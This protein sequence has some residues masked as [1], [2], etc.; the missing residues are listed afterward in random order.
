MA[1]SKQLQ[2]I[3]EAIMTIK[4][5]GG[6]FGR[7]PTFNNVTIEGTL[8]FDGDIDINSDLTISGNLYLPGNSKAIF[9]DNDDLQIY[10]DGSNSYISEVGT[11]EL[12]IQ[13]RDAVTIEDGTSGDNYMYMQR[14]NKVSLFYAGAQKL[15]TTSTGID[16]TGSVTADGLLSGTT[17][18]YEIGS[19][20]NL[21]TNAWLKNGGRVYFGDTGT[22]IYGSSSLDI[23][24]FTTNTSE[25]MRIDAGKVGIGT[26]TPVRVLDIATTTGGTIIH[27]TDDAT[28]HT[29]TDG[30]DL[31]QEGTLFQILNREAGDIRFGTNNTERLR[32]DAS[33]NL[34]VARTTDNNAV[35]GVT[36]S[37]VGIVKATRT[38][39]SLLLNRIGSTSGSLALFQYDGGTVG[40]I[41]VTA[42][43]T[44]YNTSSDQRLKENIADADD[45]GSKIDAIQVRK[46]D[47]KADG[48]HQDYGMV[49]QELLEVAPEAVSAS[50]DPEEMMGV[51]YSK[52][53]PMLIKEVQS[54][55][56]RVAQLES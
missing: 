20:S 9:G 51:D 46:F 50:E 5:L 19:S 35:A 21:W 42:S 47:W 29:A 17:A 32:I 10:H 3:H 39:W 13:A 14:G 43:A 22:A 24:S 44:A 6:V 18:T 37:N 48:S 36:L 15:A 31:Q 23:I 8:T 2:R 40:S 27:L 34:L 56:A 45:A 41:S 30:V 54:L 49:A 4:Q 1:L 12:V 28:G 55:R 25:A 16:V 38:D 26:T 11:G 33:G 7:N 53:V 52:L